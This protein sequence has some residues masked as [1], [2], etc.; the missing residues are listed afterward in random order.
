MNER[1]ERCT[2]LA[3]VHDHRL[4]HFLPQVGAHDLDEGDLEGGDLAVPAKSV[5]GT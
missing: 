1:S 2:H 3:D 5:I 4:M